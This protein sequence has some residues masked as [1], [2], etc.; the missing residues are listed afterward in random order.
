VGFLIFL[1]CVGCVEGMPV[2]YVHGFWVGFV[3]VLLAGAAE[4]VD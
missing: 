2:G 4:W 3:D 1:F